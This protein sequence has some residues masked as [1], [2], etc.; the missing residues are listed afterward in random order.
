MQF[1][2]NSYTYFIVARNHSF[3]ISY[4]DV[5]RFQTFLIVY[6]TYHSIALFLVTT[7]QTF[8][9]FHHHN[10]LNLD[11]ICLVIPQ[12]QF[13]F[14]GSL[15]DFCWIIFFSEIKKRKDI[16]SD[17]LPYREKNCYTNQYSFLSFFLCRYFFFQRRKVP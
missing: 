6:L 5:P 3:E 8:C 9:T 13:I 10:C 16:I 15:D 11:A 2:A 1:W 7:F 12:A 17:A 4:H 14:V